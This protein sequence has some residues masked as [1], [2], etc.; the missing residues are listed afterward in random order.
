MRINNDW[1]ARLIEKTSVTW[2]TKY[3]ELK[4][5][6]DNHMIK[7]EDDGHTHTILFVYPRED[8]EF[9][10]LYTWFAEQVNYPGLYDRNNSDAYAVKAY[11]CV[12]SLEYQALV[13]LGVSFDDKL[14]KLAHRTIRNKRM[15]KRSGGRKDSIDN[16]LKNSSLDGLQVDEVKV[17][18]KK[19]F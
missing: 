9:N 5:N 3:E 6:K 15:K 1:F 8:G 11:K 18:K 16:S 17:N 13:E 7:F 12:G 10:S 2:W 4:N 14:N 19:T